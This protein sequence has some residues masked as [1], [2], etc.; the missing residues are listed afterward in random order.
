MTT[1]YIY[2]NLWKATEE[3][4]RDCVWG[5]KQGPLISWVKKRFTS[6]TGPFRILYYINVLPDEN[7]LKTF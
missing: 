6:H 3:T 4:L 2:L 1:K 7:V 5:R